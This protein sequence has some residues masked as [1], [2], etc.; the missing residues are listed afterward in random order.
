M[1]AQN[2][3]VVLIFSRS[4]ASSRK[5]CVVDGQRPLKQAANELSNPLPLLHA[6]LHVVGFLQ[7]TTVT[8]A[9]NC[10]S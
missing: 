7:R 2:G 9:V 3:G 8:S 6:L 4:C 1:S 10:R 5:G